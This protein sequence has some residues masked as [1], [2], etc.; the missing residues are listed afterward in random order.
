M[1]D[2]ILRIDDTAKKCGFSRSMIWAKLNPNDRR[3]DDTFPRPIRLSARAI[4]WLESE[5]DV[6]IATR[7][8]NNRLNT[9][10]RA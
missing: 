9:E 10:N 4:G 3:H 2:T 7:A 5:I 1:K 6:W 8:E